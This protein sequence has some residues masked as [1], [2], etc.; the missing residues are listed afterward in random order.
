MYIINK[1]NEMKTLLNGLWKHSKDAI[2]SDKFFCAF[3]SMSI[4]KLRDH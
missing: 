4:V 3:Y 2:S 1:K